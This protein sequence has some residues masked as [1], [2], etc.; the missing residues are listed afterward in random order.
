[1]SAIIAVSEIEKKLEQIRSTTTAPT[2]AHKG[3]CSTRVRKRGGDGE[4]IAEGP[5]CSRRAAVG[6][7]I[8]GIGDADE[9]GVPA[10]NNGAA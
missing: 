4:N 3:R 9:T 10:K 6:R 7:G 1:L 5:D 2:C 8:E